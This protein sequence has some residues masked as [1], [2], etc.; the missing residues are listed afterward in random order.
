MTKEK[1]QSHLTKIDRGAVDARRALN[2]LA[3]LLAGFII[4]VDE[5]IGLVILGL[6]LLVI[7]YFDRR[8]KKEIDLFTKDQS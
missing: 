7:I 8:I 4:M 5:P 3:G 2:F 6:G 1:K